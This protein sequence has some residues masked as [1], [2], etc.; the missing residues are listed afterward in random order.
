MLIRDC[1]SIFPR[2]EREASKISIAASDARAV[3]TGKTIT[4][5]TTNAA[6]T[7]ILIADI[8]TENLQ[9]I[10]S[11]LNKLVQKNIGRFRQYC[12]RFKR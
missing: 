7:A 12:D 2:M 10:C 1:P 11:T 3:L 4:S 5:A 6:K 9:V 8:R